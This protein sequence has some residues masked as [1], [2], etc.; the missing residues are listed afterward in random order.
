MSAQ[1]AKLDRICAWSENAASNG[2]M[3]TQV[4]EVIDME[5]DRTF[6]RSI[7]ALYDQHL[8]PM[9]FTPYAEDLAS[10]LADLRQGC[11]LE[12]AVGTGV[13]TRALV[14]AGECFHR[15]HRP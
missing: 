10:R 13:V 3:L 14:S 1:A 9:I 2:V 12:T 4:R 5:A 6:R 7:P 11:I 15:G 8:R